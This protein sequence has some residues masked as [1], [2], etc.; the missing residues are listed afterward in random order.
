MS[1]QR[2]PQ[3][4]IPCN[5][6]CSTVSFSELV[7]LSQ[8]FTVKIPKTDNVSLLQGLIKKRQ[9]PRLNYLAAS[10]LTLSQVSL[11]KDSDLEERLKNAN[12]TPLEPILP[13]G[14]VFPC[15]EEN[16][17]HIVV[18][19]PTNGQPISI[20]LHGKENMWSLSKRVKAELPELAELKQVLDAPLEDDEK[21]PISPCLMEALVSSPFELADICTLDD[22]KLLFQAGYG[23]TPLDEIF[24]TVIKSPPMTGTENSFHSF[25]DQNVRDILEIVV[26][27]GRS[28]RNSSRHTAAWS[29][30][31]DYAFLLDKIC[32]FHGEEKGPEDNESPKAELAKKLAWAYE[33]APYILGYYAEGTDL[34]LVAISPP[35]HP[36]SLPVIHDIA[37]LI[38]SGPLKPNSLE[39]SQVEIAGHY[40]VK[41]YTGPDKFEHV[42][43]LQNVYQILWDKMVGNTDSLMNHYDATVVLPPRGIADPP[44]TEQ[45]L[46]SAVI[47]ILEAL[48]ALHK[49]A[50]LFHRDLCWPNV[51]RSLDNPQAWFII[52]WEDTGAPPT[53]AL[54]HFS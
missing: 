23:E 13:L 47:C 21:I 24:F 19:A 2:L 4:L 50:P 36:R 52:D 31:P 17:L 45:E 6:S 53:K 49:D 5:S 20:F 32:P 3:L 44:K 34:T 15:V 16:H 54:S 8:I 48:V 29:L 35:P 14:Q 12:L 11:P 38:L 22:V 7:E 37:R 26:P 51:M 25:W 39:D 10:D 43:H 30:R 18:Q 46:I 41:T 27:C 1:L 40:I 28:M 9:S 33:P 42:R